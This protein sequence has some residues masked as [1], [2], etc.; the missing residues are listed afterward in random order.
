MP[1]LPEVEVIRR[2]LGETVLH[3]TI[4]SIRATESNYTFLTPPRAL[5]K[6]LV[7]QQFTRLNRRGKYLLFELE[8]QGCLVIHLGMTGQLFSSRALSPRLVQRSARPKA[9]PSARFE[10]DKHTHLTIVFDDAGDQLHF[11]DCRKFGKILWLGTHEHSPRLDRLGPDAAAITAS[12]LTAALLGR[13]A[14]I[15][16]LLLDQ[17]ILAGVGNIYADES[18]HSAGISP[19][20]SA[21][22]LNS[23]ELAHLALAIRH[24]LK[25]AIALG[26][27]SIDDYLHPDGSDGSFQKQFSVY[28]REG[29]VCRRCGGRIERTVMAQ[30]SAHYC[31]TC[32]L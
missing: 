31:P 15:K 8:R 32:Q 27:S 4:A 5:R 24:V 25:R 23:R 17:S 22:D 2:R 6:Y 9:H 19:A 3:R 30:R 26:G 12:Q 18:L 29:Q 1:E 20:R 28:G 11:R 21:H 14:A 10:P 13:H 7:G 16:T